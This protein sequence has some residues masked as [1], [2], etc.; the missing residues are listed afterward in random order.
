MLSKF[1]IVANSRNRTEIPLY[2]FLLRFFLE[3]KLNDYLL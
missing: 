2:A 1:I 3:K